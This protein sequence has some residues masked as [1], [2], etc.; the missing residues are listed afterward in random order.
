MMTGTITPGVQEQ[1]IDQA[2]DK[3]YEIRAPGEPMINIRAKTQI[4]IDGIVRY[5]GEQ[6]SLPERQGLGL[7]GTGE[8][9]QVIDPLRP[10]TW[11]DS[12]PGPL[13]QY[14]L[15]SD[16]STQGSREGAIASNRG[17]QPGGQQSRQQVGWQT[18]VELQPQQ[19][20]NYRGGK[21][22]MTPSSGQFWREGAVSATSGAVPL[23]QATWV[24]PGGPLAPGRG[25]DG[26]A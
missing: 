16:F 2:W 6:F 15:P 25:P 24:E 23:Q 1:K 18:V 10:L 3:T 17:G 20:D 8:A 22:G 19:F 14:N 5:M 26:K 4:V 13:E 12:A 7:V 21:G 9:E 11:M